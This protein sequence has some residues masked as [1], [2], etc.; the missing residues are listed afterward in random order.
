MLILMGQLEKM[1][2]RSNPGWFWLELSTQNC[3]IKEKHVGALCSS[4]PFK[5]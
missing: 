1:W 4:G 5:D 3:E 2:G